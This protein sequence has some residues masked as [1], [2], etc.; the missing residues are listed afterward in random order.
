M[1]PDMEVCTND[2][3]K[4]AQEFLKNVSFVYVLYIITKHINHF[5]DLTGEIFFDAQTVSPLHFKTDFKIQQLQHA[6]L[7]IDCTFFIRNMVI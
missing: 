2:S 3:N 7:T 5:S 6:L 4:F 1:M